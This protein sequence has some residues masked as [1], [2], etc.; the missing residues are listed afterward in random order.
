MRKKVG[1]FG[2][3]ALLFDIQIVLLR[4]HPVQFLTN[5]LERW[6]T[7]VICLDSYSLKGTC[8]VILRTNPVIL[9]INKVNKNDR[10]SHIATNAV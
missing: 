4:K 8:I 2:I 10:F 5:A 9:K 7:L 6:T 3:C 1:S